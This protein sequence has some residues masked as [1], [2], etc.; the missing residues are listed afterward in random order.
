MKE[1]ERL[2]QETGGTRIYVETSQRPQ[3]AA[4]QA[5]YENRGYRQ[6]SVL[7]D[8]YGPGDAKVTYCKVLKS[9][10]EQQNARLKSYEITP[11]L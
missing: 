6:E 4:T 3:Y 9:M 5:F 7:E 8:F 1:I 10:P 2:V 11:E